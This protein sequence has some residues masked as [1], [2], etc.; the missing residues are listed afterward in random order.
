[1]SNVE[2]SESTVVRTERG[3]TIAGTRITL[4]DVMEYLKKDWPPA[5]IQKWLNLSEEQIQGAMQFIKDNREEVQ[6]EYDY[7]LQHAQENR[8]YWENRNRERLEKIAESQSEHAHEEIYAKI[9]KRKA[10]LGLK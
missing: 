2:T 1:M 10:E 8:A 6:T 3:L 4:Y 7:V 9:Q 5:L